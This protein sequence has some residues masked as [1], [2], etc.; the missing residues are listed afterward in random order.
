MEEREE[1]NED[2]GNGCRALAVRESGWHKILVFAMSLSKISVFA[3][4]LYYQEG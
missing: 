4:K 1:E 3:I 2:G